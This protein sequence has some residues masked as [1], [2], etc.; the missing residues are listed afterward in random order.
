MERTVP[1]LLPLLALG[2]C[3]GPTYV[4][5]PETND[6]ARIANVA[7]ARYAI[8][9][10]AP[11]GDI[12]LASF[13]VVTVS[14]PGTPEFHVLHLRM[15]I[16]NNATKPWTVSM[17][18]QRVELE[19]Y[20][21][22]R[23]R[24][25]A[26][27]VSELPNIPIAPGTKRALDFYFSLPAE[28]EDAGG[29]PAFDVIWQVATDTRVVTERTPFERLRAVT[30]PYNDGVGGSFSANPYYPGYR[31][32]LQSERYADRPALGVGGPG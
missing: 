22:R 20:G 11:N 2:A 25:V 21:V 14:S 1:L 12:R 17:P 3:A 27:P 6:S 5:R 7:A 28:I 18:K 8:P 16:S 29:I 15:A 13:G 24:Y 32:R 19:G 31:F 4:F 10:E 26:V 23:A 9:P 30:D